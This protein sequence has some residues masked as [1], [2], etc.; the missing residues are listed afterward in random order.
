[1]RRLLSISLW[2]AL[3]LPAVAQAQ[4]HDDHRDDHHDKDHHDR[5]HHEDKDHPPHGEPPPGPANG[6]WPTE[7]PPPPRE[8]RVMAARAGFYWV[9]GRWD[10]RDRKWV[11]QEGRWEKEQSGRHWRDA[12]WDHK[13]DHW[14]FADGGWEDGGMAPVGHEPDPGPRHGEHR[15]EWKIDRPV[16]SSYWPNKGKVGTKV[17]I[18]GDNFPADAMVMWGGQEVKAAKITEHE[19]RFEVPA[20]ATSATIMFHGGHERRPLIVG[21]FE[22]ASDF[23]PI[24]DQKR[25]DD[26]RRKAAEAAWNAQAAKWAKDR[27]AREAEYG[28]RWDEMEHN[29]EQRRLEREREIRAKWEAAFLGDPDTQAELT[30]HARRVAE[31]T[32]MK[33]VAA[34]QGEAKLGVRI[35]AATDRENARHDARMAALHD[36]FKGGAK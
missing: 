32:R 23:E 19:I 11:W 15:H 1:M 7:A 28:R 29:R 18:R 17:V 24:A 21:N 4:P 30:L 10:W 33:D 31:L 34:I 36:S 2:S 13:G 3:A 14:E 6:Q 16:V 25:I 20:G 35:E 22:V 8:E 26:E 12:R 9:K 27:A 5:D